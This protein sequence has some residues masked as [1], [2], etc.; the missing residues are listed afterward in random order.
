MNRHVVAGALGLLLGYLFL[1][2]PEIGRVVIGVAALFLG[3][4]YTRMRRQV[5]VG[6]LL[7]GAAVA[8]IWFLGRGALQS[9]SDP[10]IKVSGDWWPTLGAFLGFAVVGGIVVVR[11]RHAPSAS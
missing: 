11:F 2:L 10:A 7:L 4:A 5:D 9:L 8:P 3:A 1:Q 6:W